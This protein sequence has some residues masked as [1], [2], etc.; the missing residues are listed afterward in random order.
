MYWLSMYLLRFVSN[1][2]YS[3]DGRKSMRLSSST[4]DVMA[5]DGWLESFVSINILQVPIMFHIV[6]KTSGVCFCTN[7]VRH[8]REDDSYK[9]P[10]FIYKIDTC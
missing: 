5:C 6:V 1:E 10:G 2:F 8:S 7:D 9:N 4:S 3:V